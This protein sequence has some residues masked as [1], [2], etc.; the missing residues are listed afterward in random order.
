M[1]IIPNQR[2]CNYVRI[3]IYCELIKME[4]LGHVIGG[5]TS[6]LAQHIFGLGGTLVQELA[7]STNSSI[8]HGS[9]TSDSD[10]SQPKAHGEQKFGIYKISR[11]FWPNFRSLIEV[12]IYRQNSC[13]DPKSYFRFGF[14]THEYPK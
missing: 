2:E 7:R 14:L 10:S 1:R 11:T 5:K 3:S 8:F 6:R 9:L 12:A 13:L 4:G